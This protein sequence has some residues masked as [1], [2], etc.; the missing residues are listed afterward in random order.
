M[1][2][3]LKCPVKIIDCF[4]ISTCVVQHILKQTNNLYMSSPTA[5]LQQVSQMFHETS[6][7]VET[8]AYRDFY[9]GQNHTDT[10]GKG[11]HFFVYLFVLFCFMFCCVLCY[12]FFTYFF[13]FLFIYL[14]CCCCFFLI[15]LFFNFIF[16]I[17]I[18]IRKFSLL[19][20]VLQN[21]KM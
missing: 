21:R 8:Q 5:L 17:V 16:N 7:I 12:L 9:G 18:I 10:R 1:L 15:I 2:L 4:K 13:S 14:F 6:Q 19:K 3:I 11:L 20:D